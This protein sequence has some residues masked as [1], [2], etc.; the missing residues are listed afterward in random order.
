MLDGVGSLPLTKFYT[1]AE[2]KLSLFMFSVYQQDGRF[3]TGNAPEKEF[4]V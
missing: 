1:M 2:S 4:L 3:V